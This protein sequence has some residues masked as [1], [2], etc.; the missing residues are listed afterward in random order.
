M[1]LRGWLWARDPASSPL[2]G[3]AWDGVLIV[4]LDAVLGGTRHMGRE[5]LSRLN[6]VDERGVL[7]Q[8]LLERDEHLPRPD[9]VQVFTQDVGVVSGCGFGSLGLEDS[10]PELESN[11]DAEDGEKDC[12]HDLHGQLALRRR[13]GIEDVGVA[14]DRSRH[15]GASCR[16]RISLRNALQ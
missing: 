4:Y 12:Q 9:I 8:E 13:T 10:T 1:G 5:R 3:M 2:G 6:D 16:W 11:T 15:L 7:A 14:G